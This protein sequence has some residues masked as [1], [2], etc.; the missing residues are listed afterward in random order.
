MEKL[1]NIIYAGRRKFVELV[2]RVSIEQLNEIP[3]GFNNNIAWNFGH[4]VI[5]QQMLCYVRAGIKPH[6]DEYFIQKYQKGTKPGSFIAA[7]E[8]AVLKALTFSLIDELKE[9]LKKDKF[10]GYT[11]FATQ[12]GVELTGIHDAIAY[13][14]THDTLHLGYAMAIARRVSAQNN[15]SNL[16]HIKFSN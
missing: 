1:F 4:I 11:T 14:A 12:F 13:F 5:S 7:S 3:Q 9:D 10:T 15:F 2:D 6:I 8:I 16:Q